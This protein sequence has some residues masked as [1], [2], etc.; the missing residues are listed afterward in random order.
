[1]RVHR[2]FASPA[3][4]LA[5]ALLAV[6]TSASAQ[7]GQP[8]NPCRDSADSD[9]PSH[10]EVRELA[11]PIV[12]DLLT[13]DAMPN[14]GISVHG[15]NRH[16]I[17]LQAKVTASADTVEQAR[18]LAGQV[19]VLTD[20]GRLRA[21]GPRPQDGSG[22]SVSYDV[23]VP[24]QWNLDLATRNGGVSIAGVQGQIAFSTTN[25][26]VRLSDVNGDVKGSTVNGGVRVE[27]T[28]AGWDGE[29]LDVETKNGGVKL[30]VPDGYSAHL[31]T[32]THNGGLRVDFPVTVQG[33]VRREINTDLGNG[34]A[35]IRLRTVNGGVTVEKK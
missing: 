24:S 7:T 5:A 17:Q 23:M 6:A 21:E 34:G 3:P 32:G 9:R 18:A 30:S 4:V 25:G 35:P 28:G 26:G 14:G 11:V 20:G 12:G 16:E 15:W 29:G 33:D 22:W 10:C 2:L 19:R 31:E 8:R 27:L 13:V 1:M